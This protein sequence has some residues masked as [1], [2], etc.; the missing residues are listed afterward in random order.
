MKI[1]RLTPQVF[2]NKQKNSK[3][4]ETSR[5]RDQGVI[6]H[7]ASNFPAILM[8]FIISQMEGCMP[9]ESIETTAMQ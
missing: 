6:I 9:S 3:K 1:T 8:Y 7:L 5:L 4:D 2:K